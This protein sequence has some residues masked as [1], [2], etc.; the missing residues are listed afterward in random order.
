MTGELFFTLNLGVL[1]A[2]TKRKEARFFSKE[3]DL[4]NFIREAIRLIYH[5]VILI[6]MYYLFALS[7]ASYGINEFWGTL[8]IF[9]VAW[10]IARIQKMKQLFLF[11]VYSV[12]LFVLFQGDN[13]LFIGRTLLGVEITFKI[14]LFQIIVLGANERIRFSN[15]PKEMEG[16]PIF[17]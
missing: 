8:L 7:L 6:G 9:P 1:L 12:V 3:A 4:E 5:T 14:F 2:W 13:S 17:F 15:I 16:I 11:V 10:G